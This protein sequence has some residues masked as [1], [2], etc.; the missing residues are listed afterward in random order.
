MTE[1]AF[2][3]Y[4]IKENEALESKLNQITH[5]E[6][7]I[8]QSE[9]GMPFDVRL[10]CVIIDTCSNAKILTTTQITKLISA[11]QKHLTDRGLIIVLYS[12]GVNLLRH[13]YSA[14]KENL[15][16]KEFGPVQQIYFDCRAFTQLDKSFTT[17]FSR[18]GVIYSRKPTEF[19]VS[20]HG[21]ANKSTHLTSGER[22]LAP[23]YSETPKS[24]I[25]GQIIAE[26]LYLLYQDDW[27]Y[28]LVC[29]LGR[30][31][32]HEFVKREPKSPP[33]ERFQFKV[34]QSETNIR[35]LP[36]V[37]MECAM[38]GVAVQYLP[39]CPTQTQVNEMIK[40]GEI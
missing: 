24:I 35:V 31:F 1:F 34:I 5:A 12:D 14:S 27:K 22:R 30:P 33:K 26:L 25:D 23:K 11:T 7:D 40:N 10:D 13:M 39:S 9:P 28:V 3:Y 17:E 2:H 4:N 20:K 29:N 18:I 15:F 6:L 8:E 19:T 37:R 32:F 38:A 36:D 21:P 16:H